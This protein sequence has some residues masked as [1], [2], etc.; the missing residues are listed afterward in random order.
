MSKMKKTPKKKSLMA[1]LM[2][3]IGSRRT[4]MY[5]SAIFSVIGH[6]VALLPPLIVW[7]IIRDLLSPEGHSLASIVGKAWGALGCGV[8]YLVLYLVAL[9]LSH[10]AAFRTERSLRSSSMQRALSMPLG[11]FDRNSSGKLRKIIDENAGLIHSYIAHQFPDLLAGATCLFAFAVLLFLPDWRLG[12]ISFVPILISCLAM[13]SM[14]GN[15][16]YKEGMTQYLNHLEKMNGEA[17][18]FVRG[19]PVVKTFQQSVYSFNR[20]YKTIRDYQIWVTRYSVSCTKAMTIYTIASNSF[21]FFIIPLALYFVLGRGESLS[22]MIPNL[23]FYILITPFYPQCMMKLMF[24][25]SN[26]QIAAQA[27]DRIDALFGKEES[28]EGNKVLKPIKHNIKLE[29]VSFRYSQESPLAVKDFSLEIPEG[30]T[31]ALVGASGSGKTTIARLVA[32]FWD[33]ETGV[34]SIGEQDL[35]DCDPETIHSEVS[36]VFQNEKLFKTSIRENITYSNEIA[37]EEEIEKAIEMAQCKDIIDK[38]PQGIDTKIGVNGIYLSG[39]EQQR[40]ALA[41]AFLKNS[42]ILLLDEAT[43][44]ADAENEKAIQQALKNLMKQ[45]TVLLIAHRLTSVIDAD[46]IIVMAKGQIAEMGSHRELL[47]KNALYAQMWNNYQNATK[48]TL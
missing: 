26:K 27:L 3:H 8:L 13:G 42:P 23:V 46:K 20:F 17:V 47:E 45:K 40:I 28:L 15:K 29:R 39:G 35:K 14:M 4:L 11:F 16:A 48:W 22:E 44:F 5:F 30:A 37:T 36:F 12:L 33:P 1:R 10:V 18:E 41:R 25:V 2:V 21:I 43:A 38:L 34:V 6:L 31:Y 24:M 7:M 19:M 9:M 32:R